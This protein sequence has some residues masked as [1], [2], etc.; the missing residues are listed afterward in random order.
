M[1]TVFRIKGFYFT[2]YIRSHY[3]SYRYD[4]NY[5]IFVKSVSGKPRKGQIN[6]NNE[7]GIIKV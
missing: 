4:R 5:D 2:K 6:N 7:V 1:D 3:Y